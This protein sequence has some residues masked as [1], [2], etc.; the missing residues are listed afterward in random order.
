MI[1]TEKFRFAKPVK[2]PRPRWVTG[3]GQ[4]GIDRAFSV[5]MATSR[6]IK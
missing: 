4:R 2:V 3:G 1:G 5:M 6:T